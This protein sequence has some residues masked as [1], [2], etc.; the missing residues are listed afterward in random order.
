MRFLFWFLAWAPLW[1]AAGFSRLVTWLWWWVFPYRKSLAV[2]NFSLAFPD[3]APGPALRESLASMILSIAE[4]QREVRKPKLLLEFTGFEPLVQRA[5]NGEGS[6]VLTGHGGAWE[7]LGLAASRNLGLPITVIVRHISSPAVRS[8][9]EKMRETSGLEVLPPVGSFFSASKA[10]AQGRVVVFLLDQRHNQGLNV[11]FLGRPALTSKALALLAKR[12]GVPV[13]GG[14]AR[15]E[16]R[17]HH[18]FELWGP[19]DTQGEVQ[20]DTAMFMEFTEK[21]IRER[22]AH[23]L[24]LHDR[25]KDSEGTS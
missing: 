11:P 6:L 17:G 12:S 22:P 13:F 4:L 3:L 2:K 21:R 1:M 14:W 9:I 18:H 23:W 10:L 20:Q 8:V 24:W 15:R 7:L 5:K 19:L 25:W 16:G